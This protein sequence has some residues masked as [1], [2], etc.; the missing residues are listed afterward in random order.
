VTTVP[1]AQAVAGWQVDWFSPDVNV[2]AAHAS[3]VRSA[4]A[5][6]GFATK[7]PAGQE[8][9]VAQLGA[10]VVVLKVPLTQP[11]HA[12]SVARKVPAEQLPASPVP[13]V[14]PVASL[15]SVLL[16]VPSLLLVGHPARTST[17]STNV[18]TWLTFRVAI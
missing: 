11:E 8:L 2:P 13:P 10:S 14:V 9:Q 4:V 7:V 12:P 17:L 6:G 18:A 5:E 15:P 16:L 1:A 3:H